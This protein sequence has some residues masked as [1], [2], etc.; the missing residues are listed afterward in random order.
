MQF[1]KW[2]LN[3]RG[4]FEKVTGDLLQKIEIKDGQGSI[5]LPAHT[6]MYF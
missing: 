5:S 4:A 6:V 3:A 2:D 1:W